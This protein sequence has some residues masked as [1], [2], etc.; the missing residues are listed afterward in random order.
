MPFSRV[1]A[2]FLSLHERYGPI[3]TLYIGSKPL[4]VIASH[5][6]AHQALIDNS[7]IFADRPQAMATDKFLSCDQ[8]N[9]SSAFYSPT[10]L[11]LRRNLTYN[12]LHTLRIKSFACARKW[13]LDA[14]INRLK[15]HSSSYEYH[16]TKIRE[17]IQHALYS[18]F[19]FICFGEKLEDKKI[20]DIKDLQ[21]RLQLSFDEFK[22][23][24]LFPSL[25]KFVFHKRWEKLRQLRQDQEKL[26]VPLI[27]ARKAMREGKNEKDEAFLP[28]V[29]TLFDLQLKEENRKL[30]EKEIV[31][32]CS[33]FFTGGIDTTSTTLEWIMASLVKHP[34]IQDKLFKEIKGVVSDGEVEIK[35]GDLR[36]MPYLRAVILES[37]RR[38]PPSHFL[39]PHTVTKNVV[40]G[41]FLVP[42]NSIVI[43]IVVETGRNPNVWEN[44]MEFKPERFLNNGDFD[45]SGTKEIKMMPFGVGKRMCP[46]YRLAMLHLK[47]FVANLVWHFNFNC[48]GEGVDLTEKHE[49]TAVMQN[50]LEVQIAPRLYVQ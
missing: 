34:H 39:I 27:K 9:I 38:H 12:I 16:H 44:P 31:A 46:A 42:K 41:G 20:Q 2:L 15:S 40:L 33:E 4:I 11:R 18:L 22:V 43:F 5:S 3:Y 35:D 19:A 45:I 36:K 8:Q 25:G 49:F 48:F 24:N 17:H 47:Y 26:M 29:D 1:K 23:L 28:Y 21:R 14:L 30:E 6:L 32:L 13:A 7:I 37:L 10:W 50:P